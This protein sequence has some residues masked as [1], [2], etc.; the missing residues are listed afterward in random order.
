MREKKLLFMN[1]PDLPLPVLFH[2]NCRPPLQPLPSR[3][4]WGKCEKTQ[5]ERKSFFL[6]IIPIKFPPFE[7]TLLCMACPSPRSCLPYYIL[8]STVCPFVDANVYIMKKDDEETQRMIESFC[9]PFPLYIMTYLYLFIYYR[10]RIGMSKFVCVLVCHHHYIHFTPAG[11]LQRRNA[12]HF[13]LFQA[14]FLHSQHRDVLRDARL[15]IIRQSLGKIGNELNEQC[16]GVCAAVVRICEMKRTIYLM[17]LNEW[18][19]F[20]LFG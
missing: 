9:S 20:L 18:M 3:R 19:V 1:L 2:S 6:L 4:W 16:V 8:N 5:I 12:R 14:I 15:Y 7:F 17:M 13:I 11:L 10:I